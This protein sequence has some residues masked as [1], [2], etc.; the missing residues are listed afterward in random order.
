MALHRWVASA[1]DFLSGGGH[2]TIGVVHPRA[3]LPPVCIEPYCGGFYWDSPPPAFLDRRG[4][5]FPK[6]KEEGDD[7]PT[8]GL[9]LPPVKMPPAPAASGVQAE[10]DALSLATGE[11]PKNEVQA[12]AVAVMS[13][14][15]D[16]RHAK[17]HLK[18]LDFADVL[19]FPHRD[20]PVDWKIK[21]GPASADNFDWWNVPNAV[22][23]RIENTRQGKQQRDLL[24]LALNS[25]LHLTHQ[26]SLGGKVIPQGLQIV[27]VKPRGRGLRLYPGLGDKLAILDDPL[28]IELT[29][30]GKIAGRPPQPNDTPLEDLRRGT[31]EP[32]KVKRLD[33]VFQPHQTAKD[34]LPNGIIGPPGG[35]PPAEIS[36]APLNP[37]TG[38]PRGAAALRDFFAAVA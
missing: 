2:K 8:Y 14:K 4:K 26:V 28:P 16:K 25:W 13:K 35:V 15:I 5:P 37:N 36:S 31:S 24:P 12:E 33:F 11:E 3:D 34:V 23:V 38:L 1:E 18:R 21:L 7:D 20:A 22:R 30:G 17:G 32:V 27:S 10:E 19:L 29:F 6:P 9:P